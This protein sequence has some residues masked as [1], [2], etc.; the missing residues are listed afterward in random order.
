MLEY[1]T[2]NYT[3][4]INRLVEYSFHISFSTL[5]IGVSPGAQPHHDW[6]DRRC[7]G[8]CTRPEILTGS[9]PESINLPIKAG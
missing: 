7:G 1:T 6:P 9:I 3:T 2:R 8:S 4:R 5:Q